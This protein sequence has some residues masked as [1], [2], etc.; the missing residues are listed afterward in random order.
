MYSATTLPT[1]DGWAPYDLSMWQQAGAQLRVALDFAQTA[2]ATLEP[3]VGET[4]WQSD[5][6]RALHD[7]LA[8]Q[9]GL[10]TL[11]RMTLESTE[12][13]HRAVAVG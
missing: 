3:L 9:R 1:T 11:E 7:T 6:L 8:E 4:E 10:L 5:G 12:A 13:D 2:A